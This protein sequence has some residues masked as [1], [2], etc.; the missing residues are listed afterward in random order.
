MN[1]IFNKVRLLG[2]RFCG[3]VFM[4]FVGTHQVLAQV[5]SNTTNSLRENSLCD[6]LYYG[7]QTP[8]NDVRDQVLRARYSN[9]TND[10]RFATCGENGDTP[11]FAAILGSDHVDKVDI[12]ITYLGLDTSEV[13]S[14]VNSWGDTAESLSADRLRLAQRRMERMFENN[15]DIFHS[16]FGSEVTMNGFKAWINSNSYS[17]RDFGPEITDSREFREWR[18]A[19]QINDLIRLHA[20]ENM[21]QS[22]ASRTGAFIE[23]LRRAGFEWDFR[24]I[25][26]PP[27]NPSDS[28][29]VSRTPTTER[30]VKVHLTAPSSAVRESLLELLRDIT[31]PTTPSSSDAGETA[32]R[33]CPAYSFPQGVFDLLMPILEDFNI[34]NADFD[35]MSITVDTP[36][37]VEYF[38]LTPSQLQT[39]KQV[40]ECADN[41]WP[42]PEEATSPTPPF[43]DAANDGTM[44]ASDGAEP[45]NEDDIG[46]QLLSNGD[47]IYDAIDEI[48][49]FLFSEEGRNHLRAF[50]SELG[51]NPESRDIILYADALYIERLKTSSMLEAEE[52]RE[53]LG[54]PFIAFERIH[55]YNIAQELFSQKGRLWP[56]RIR[57]I[58]DG[59][60][61]RILQE[62]NQKFLRRLMEDLGYS[63][64]DIRT[65]GSLYFYIEIEYSDSY[66]PVSDFLAGRET[67]LREWI[68][69]E[70]AEEALPVPD[71]AGD[72]DC[73]SCEMPET[74]EHETNKSHTAA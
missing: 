22:T 36:D 26:T 5:S 2:F 57:N 70:R 15:P 44:D 39:L 29:D 32:S 73:Q 74:H 4:F 61:N 54:V 24:I 71:E 48:V 56:N 52:E 62:E 12:L 50:M 33:E 18:V 45:T 41:N 25:T 58:I 38:S 55:P 66:Y 8:I 20:F 9:I 13:M 14:Y 37:G 1:S 60:T 31:N 49:M 42:V 7:Q 64:V 3:I 6:F 17:D 21:A 69:I 72:E 19:Q 34:E 10:I 47:S 68:I 27:E 51:Y 65:M 11:L 16:R 59:L 53:R 40:M 67:S 30:F 43:A 63:A 23:A 35:R 28:T 46:N